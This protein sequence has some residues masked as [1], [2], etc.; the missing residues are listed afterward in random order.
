MVAGIAL[1]ENTWRYVFMSQ[2]WLVSPRRSDN[3][4]MLT[5]LKH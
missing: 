1:G 3:Y 5:V 2:R 4:L